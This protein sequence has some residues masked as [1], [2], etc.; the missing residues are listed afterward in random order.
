MTLLGGTPSSGYSQSQRAQLRSHNVAGR[1]T[2]FVKR[3]FSVSF[4]AIF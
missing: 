3:G 2:Q 1:L 4:V